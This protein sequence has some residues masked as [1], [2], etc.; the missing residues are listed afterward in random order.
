MARLRHCLAAFALAGAAAPSP[1]LAGLPPPQTMTQL[2]AMQLQ[3]ELVVNGMATGRTMSVLMER[4]RYL[5]AAEDLRYVGFDIDTLPAGQVDLA[6]VPGIA[7]AYDER[8][9]RL[10][11]QVPDD[12]LPQQSF[13]QSGAVERIRPESS[14]GAL[15]N[16]DVYVADSDGDATYASVASEIRVFGSFGV[17]RNTGV[18]RLSG[19]GGQDGYVRHDTS[20]TFV[21]EEKIRTYEVGDFVTRTLA[22]SNPARLA[23]VQIS[24][25]FAVRPDIVTYPLPIFAGK[26]SVP[27]TLDLFINGHKT[28]SQ[29]LQPGPF[30]LS[31]VPYVN[32]AGEAVMV[33]TDAQG[34]QVS[35][36]VPFYVAN[37]LLRPGLADYTLSVG[38]VRRDY[39]IRSFSYGEAAASGAVRYGLSGALTLEA[40]AQAAQSLK[41][42][43]AG[44]VLRLGNLGVLNASTTFS[45]H[46]G[47]AGSQLTFGYQYSDRRITL[48]AGHTRRSRDF[49]DL[50]G[51]GLSNFRFAKE[52]TQATASIVLGDTLGTLAASYVESE[53]R[54]DRFR[55]FGLSYYKSLWGRSSLY[56]SG[57]HEPGRGRTSAMLQLVVPLGRMGTAIAGIDRTG[58]SAVR[59]RMAY[60]R[61]VPSAGGLGWGMTATRSD[62]DG[63]QYQA[64]LTWRAQALQVQA[65]LYGGG[66]S[67]TRWSDV[68]GSLVLMDGGMFA[69]NRINDAFVLVST[70]GVAGIPI[71]YENQ[72]IGRTNGDGQ[73]LIPWASAYYSAKY[74]ID[75]LDLPSDVSTPVVAQQVAV[76]LGS[77]RI[78][79]FPVRHLAA[80]TLTLVDSQGH[81]LK[82]GTPILTD[83]GATI[84]VGW[85]GLAYL[86]GVKADNRLTATLSDGTSCTVAF[87]HDMATQ[88][89]AK[90]GALTC[91]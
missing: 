22:W 65:G 40:Q 14:T 72:E 10:L 18:Y 11:L 7:L 4:G 6:G 60:S 31:D 39:A 81:Y 64:D 52:Q 89:I 87:A 51:Y 58:D 43:G 37:T 42:V 3:L 76:K 50:S 63:A 13:S 5:I 68:S 91:R 2:P 15:L 29:S 83:D 67:Q 85:D 84:Y 35:T 9:Q 88:G 33:T 61:S 90:I 17:V 24:R 26:A 12:W 47:Q 25:D 19:P 28:A 21:D 45:Q 34:R 16:Y 69:A 75:P 71:R 54:D 20:W 44:G 77:G 59:E 30:M 80:A 41:L 86:E 8:A 57:N 53:D 78:V 32:G 23:G 66:G 79:R 1:V 62:R 46:E 73:L 55:L 48:M 38:M 49:M 74:E 36:S 27:T 56:L 70:D 82:A